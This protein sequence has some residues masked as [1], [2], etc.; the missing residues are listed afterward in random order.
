MVEV[1]NI[2]CL[3]TPALGLAKRKADLTLLQEHAAS[4]FEAARFKADFR[5]QH[6][7]ALALSPPDRNYSKAAGGVGAI[8]HLDDTLFVLDP[9]TE[10]FKDACDSGRAM[11]VAY[12]KGKGGDL[13]TFYI[14]YGF[15][16]GHASPPKA[17]GTSKLV[18]AITDEVDARPIGASFLVGDV[19]ADLPDIAAMRH[20]LSDRHWTDLGGCADQ[21]QQ[22]PNH[23]T[24]ICKQSNE[25]TRRDY[26]L[27][28][29]V[30]LQMVKHFQVSFGDM[31]PTHATLIMHLELKAPPD[32]G[33]SDL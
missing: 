11:F 5:S 2:T 28:S 9:I 7:R 10:S 22:P 8:A 23:P 29:P 31:C 25:P 19:N 30:G 1:K 15:S 20:L 21:W 3:K 16:G 6:R 32:R 14:L 17:A 33:R 18:Q 27:A 26:I 12:G 4:A 24:C 13:V